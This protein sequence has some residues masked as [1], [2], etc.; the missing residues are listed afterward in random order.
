MVDGRGIKEVCCHFVFVLSRVSGWV[1][2]ARE[3]G[4]EREREIDRNT[5][6]VYIYIYIYVY[7]RHAG[8]V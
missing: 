7:R 6:Y 5:T 2:G 3:R 4:R 1:G 8:A